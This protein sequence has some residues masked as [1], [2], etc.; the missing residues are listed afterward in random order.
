[1][2]GFIQLGPKSVK[3]G[4]DTCTVRVNSADPLCGHLDQKIVAGTNISITQ[5]AGS[6]GNAL[7]IAASGGSGAGYSEIMRVLYPET[8]DTMGKED[9]DGHWDSIYYNELG[10]ARAC[11]LN[12]IGY[13]Y[14]A[15]GYQATY[16]MAST[17]VFHRAELNMSGQFRLLAAAMLGYYD[18]STPYEATC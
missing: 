7:Q 3:S 8:V 9:A 15:N 17:R 1:M 4:S 11:G 5:V 16:M 10:T 14:V 12:L 2:A 6:S 18:A 13:D